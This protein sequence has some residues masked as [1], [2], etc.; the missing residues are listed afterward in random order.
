MKTTP[1]SYQRWTE[2]E[3][4]A[5]R[6]LPLDSKYAALAVRLGRTTVACADRAK[7]FGLPNRSE[8][9]QRWLRRE[10]RRA[11]A[12][13]LSDKAIGSALG[14][15]DSTALYWRRKMGL[16][17]HFGWGGKRTRRQLAVPQK[18]EER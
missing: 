15:S 11:W 13:G 4:Q 8:R 9:R 12:G 2:E 6:A 5:L 3:K 16:V 18:Q 14:L 1:R 17:S 10:V 7:A